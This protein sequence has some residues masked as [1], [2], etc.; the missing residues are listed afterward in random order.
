MRASG[1]ALVSRFEQC[2]ADGTPLNGAARFILKIFNPPPSGPLD[3]LKKLIFAQPGHFRV[4]VFIV[5]NQPFG[6]SKVT[7]SRDE[8]ID[9]LSSG[10]NGL[11][12]GIGD[13]QFTS[14]YL[15]TAL[16]YEFEQASADS[17]AI[18]TQPSSL[19]GK[20]HLQK[21]GIWAALERP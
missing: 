11:P 20:M 15:T 6:Q 17:A 21:S 3:Y 13:M 18:L 1:F 19:T 14:A 8:A 16:I 7:V 4:I 9:W 5:T 2:D 10:T 12:N